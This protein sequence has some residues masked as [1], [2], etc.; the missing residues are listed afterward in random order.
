MDEN[1][2]L[3]RLEAGEPVSDQELDLAIKGNP[4]RAG[5]QDM[6]IWEKNF[7]DSPRTQPTLMEILNQGAV[8]AGGRL[9]SYFKGIPGV[10]D[11]TERAQHGEIIRQMR[12][13]LPYSGVGEA[14]ADFAVGAAVPL[15]RAPGMVSRAVRTAAPQAVLG[16][17]SARGQGGNALDMARDAG[18]G[19]AGGAL[20]SGLIDTG[21]KGVNAFRGNW[22]DPQKKYL[23]DFARKELNTELRTGDL[24][25]D[26]LAR[27]A[28]YLGEKHPYLSKQNVKAEAQA[29]SLSA[30][31][32]S[33]GQN[34]LVDAIKR[35]KEQM[36][37]LTKNMWAPVQQAAAQAGGVPTNNL[38][39]TL[40]DILDTYPQVI[41]QVRN[42][43]V[44]DTITKVLGNG[45]KVAFAPNLT[46]DEV[47]EL[48]QSLGPITEQLRRQAVNGS[49]DG[50]EAQAINRLYG[51]THK[52]L[53]RWGADPQNAQ[54]Y[55]LY[56]QVND[57]YKKKVL[58]FYLN[59]I[60]TKVETGDYFHSP[61]SM[62]K[63][64]LAPSHR[65][66]REE[67]LY[68]LS[69]TDHKGTGIVETLKAADRGARRLIKDQ[70][71]PTVS[72]TMG[73]MLAPKIFAAQLSGAAATESPMMLPMIAASPY[74]GPAKAQAS[75]KGGLGQ[76]GT[77]RTEPRGER[78]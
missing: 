33:G 38:R 21:A 22:T 62:I 9:L 72:T 53:N 45:K 35:S 60:V 12:E 3:R 77:R 65:T 55:Q 43:K 49:I 32:F 27:G 40:I 57:E 63:D 23:R 26:S 78:P 24:F 54:A 31:L 10:A 42:Q 34:Q 75:L 37:L 69:Q 7:T 5:A 25:P 6:P 56:S 70:P 29:E 11:E 2:L 66:A 59:P 44:L 41:Q 73:A 28:E 36:D 18:W 48:Q 19:G 1:E 8:G 76:M 64:L 68:Y 58:P 13:E 20:A 15:A 39:S 16:A 30:S 17:D 74:L 61:E 14:V 51:A 52:D 46:F 71:E 50:K 4:V 67:L 47:R